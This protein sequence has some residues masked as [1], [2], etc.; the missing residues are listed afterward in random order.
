[1]AHDSTVSI[2][3]TIKGTFTTN[4]SPSSLANFFPES[5]EEAL[6][7]YR[8]SG[9]FSTVSEGLGDSDFHAAIAIRDDDQYSE[10]WQMFAGA[11][12]FLVPAVVDRKL[13]VDTE[14]RDR[15]GHLVGELSESE[16]GHIWMALL[17]LPAF[18]FA[19]PRTVDDDIVY[20]LNRRTIA[21]AS[22]R[23][24]FRPSPR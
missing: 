23:G 1:M 18:P 12:L 4:G 15:E 2:S 21:E 7:A 5:R 20:D 14:L 13:T 19:A 6:K 9:C 8:E 16:V 22:E 11:T 17:L 10:G 3:V 24:L